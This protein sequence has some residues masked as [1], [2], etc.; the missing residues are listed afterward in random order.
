MTTTLHLAANYSGR[1]RLPRRTARPALL[2]PSGHRTPS[3]SWARQRW[4]RWAITKCL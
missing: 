3:L 2:V 4:D 1:Q